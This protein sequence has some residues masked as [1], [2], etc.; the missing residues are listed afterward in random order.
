V[1]FGAAAQAPQ[2]MPVP[3]PA[4]LA[5]PK[6][7]DVEARRARA[8]QEPPPWAV[9]EITGE[10]ASEFVLA[11][12][13]DAPSDGQARTF[14]IASQVLPATIARRAVPR[15][16]RAVY[17]LARAER[18]AGA[19]PAG[20]LQAYRDGTLVGRVDWQPALGRELEVAL[21]QDDRMHVEVEAPGDVTGSAGV[22][23]S[24]G[25]KRAA[26]VYAIVNQHGTP[27][28][29]EVLDAAP[30]ARDEAI[31]VET[32][33]D[34]PPATTAW[35]HRAGVAAWTLALAPRQTQRI[36]VEHVVSW[37]KDRQVGALP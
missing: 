24:R 23:G 36:R 19:W 12:P 13:V 22:F 29:V 7:A 3:A 27:V 34:P 6:A 20:P 35:E 4:P 14:T 21:G 37:P 10:D 32:R 2:P 26:S 30:V 17:L 28:T 5:L 18:P 15:A 8:A 9:Q 1:V 16:D 33:F 11:Q 25:E 31:R